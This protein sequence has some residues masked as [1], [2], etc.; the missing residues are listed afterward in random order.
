MHICTHICIHVCVILQNFLIPLFSPQKLLLQLGCHKNSQII[1]DSLYY[2]Y[3]Y[4]IH[5]II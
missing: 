2:V 5:K 3:I 1:V 4:L